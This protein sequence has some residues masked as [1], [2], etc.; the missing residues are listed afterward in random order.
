MT[1]ATNDYSFMPDYLPI[2]TWMNDLIVQ[3]KTMS[4]GETAFKSLIKYPCVVQIPC[5]KCDVNKASV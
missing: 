4:D 3:V 2:I 5:G 1:A